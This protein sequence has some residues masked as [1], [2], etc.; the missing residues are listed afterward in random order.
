METATTIEKRETA[1]IIFSSPAGRTS[2]R[3]FT[4]SIMKE[5]SIAN[6]VRRVLIMLRSTFWG[7]VCTV[8][9]GE[10]GLCFMKAF[11]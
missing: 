1:P 9:E 7:G 4:T 5:S 6:T 11:R 3:S 2:L 10:G 8:C